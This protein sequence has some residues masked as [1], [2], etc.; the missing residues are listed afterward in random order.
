MYEKDFKRITNA[1]K[2]HSLTFFVGAGV[3]CISGVPSWKNIIDKI[4]TQIGKHIQEAYSA[5][6]SLRLAQMLYLFLDKDEDRYY[7][8]IEECLDSNNL[9][10]NDVHK[11]L[12]ALNPESLITTNFDD[13]L[14]TAAMQ[15]CQNFTSIACDKEVA[16]I[17]GSKYILKIHGDIK[18]KNI[19]FKEEDYLNYSENFKLIETLLKS[20]FSTNTVVFIG[21]GLNDYNV[22]LILNWAKSLLKEQFNQPIFIYTGEERLEKNELSYHDSRG[23]NVIDWH[24]F[25]TTN[26]EKNEYIYH[27]MTVLKAIKQGSDIS[28]DNIGKIEAFNI[29]YQLLN[30]LDKL[31]A[32]RPIDIRDK[33]GKYVYVNIDNHVITMSAE[34]NKQDIILQYF[35]EIHEFSR[36][37]YKQLNDTTA[38]QYQIILSVFR[39][40]HIYI[41]QNKKTINTLQNTNVA[42]A[43]P[44]CLHFDYVKMREFIST[45]ENNYKKAYY[46]YRLKKY[47][48]AY[49]LF[50]STGKNAYLSQDYILYYL[51]KINSSTLNTIRKI[52][53]HSKLYNFCNNKINIESTLIESHINIFESLPLKFQD[54]YSNLKDLSSIKQFLNTYSH[55]AFTDGIKL[56]D[57][58]ESNLIEFGY[59]TSNR[60]ISVINEYLHFILG[61]GIVIDSCTEYTDSIKYL[62]DLLI[63]KYSEQNK[64]N[65]RQTLHH[66]STNDKIHL[67]DIDFY[68]IIEYFSKD[69]IRKLFSKHQIEFISFNKWDLIKE[70]INNILSNYKYLKDSQKPELD[71]AIQQIKT[72]FALL[73]Y[74]NI[75]QETMDY[76]CN[77]MLE[78]KFYEH[79]NIT[80]IKDYVL[81][82]YKQL[83]GKEL[84][85]NITVK[86]TSKS[87]LYYL[88]TDIK[89]YQ[90]KQ[91]FFLAN[92]NNINYTYLG[93]CIYP[94]NKE[95]TIR[96][97]SYRINYIIQNNMKEFIPLICPALWNH[98][99]RNIKKKIYTYTKQQLGIKFNFE[100]F[101][102]LLLYKKKIEQNL[103]T[104]LK[105]YLNDGLE[106]ISIDGTDSNSKNIYDELGTVGY[107]CLRN[108]L[109]KDDFIE[110]IGKDNR[111]DFFLLYEQFDY[112]K[113]NIAWLIS[114]YQYP[115][116]LKYIS[117]NKLV[118]KKISSCIINALNT[119]K[120]IPYDESK[121]VQILRE[122]FL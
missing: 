33:I 36:Q 27:Y 109:N 32:L 44:Y 82:F 52:Y 103:T 25:N 116:T 87:L 7:Q 58:I 53:N 67:D 113:F 64:K 88:D 22:K 78:S 118:K 115:D 4:C 51:C 90:S 92:S 20:I 48:E 18:H 122:Y 102:I 24:Q 73:T 107:W 99:G 11:Q 49:E 100:L 31:Q 38:N 63:Y 46:L 59:T 93:Y 1:S 96:T 56:K 79:Y 70:S 80:D 5:D 16:S 75:S 30:P 54:E 61:N 72:L 69:E 26:G 62:M 57:S 39:K 108:W 101:S 66:I 42:F 17:N 28:L 119:D 41:V 6:E 19:V 81:F 91:Y 37:E 40:A 111:F 89:N 23:L 114:L 60:V 29:L 35:C 74:V 86:L 71:I 104:S 112:T 106:K 21:Y 97:L 98:L 12:F 55:I 34:N 3:S 10:P 13:L 8:F 65:I 47:N 15:E 14:E 68:C 43:D 105:K 2:N 50:Y 94:Q 45:D 117:K 83:S 85:S 84:F 76:I 77:F 110:F 120:I 9:I 95:H 121:L